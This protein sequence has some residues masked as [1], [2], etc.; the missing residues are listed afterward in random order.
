MS[1]ITLSFI[2][3][4]SRHVSPRLRHAAC[5]LP[6]CRHLSLLLRYP[7]PPSLPCQ[8]ACLLSCGACL[9][10]LRAGAA[11]VRRPPRA[12]H[13]VRPWRCAERG[14]TAR[15]VCSSKVQPGTSAPRSCWRR[16]GRLRRR[17]RDIT[18]TNGRANRVCGTFGTRRSCRRFL[19][20][21]VLSTTA[22]RRDHPLHVHLSL[23]GHSP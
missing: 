22:G 21:P 10:W 3:R 12:L 19:T 17:A 11:L 8:T 23:L 5:G 9:L 7:P 20:S 1:W 15:D 6:L 13:F 16:R 14:G 2:S 4:R 18:L